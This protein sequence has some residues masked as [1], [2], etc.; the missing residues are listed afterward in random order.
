VPFFDTAGAAQSVMDE[1]LH[2][3]GA[4]AGAFAARRYGLRILRTH[5]EDR[6]ANFT[7]FLLIARSPW[8]TRRGVRVKTSIS[9]AP[10]RN[11]VGILFRVLGVFALRDIDLLKIESRPDPGSP[12]DYL[13]YVDLAGGPHEL[14]VA[15]ALDHL[16]EMVHRYRLL[17]VYPRAR[18]PL[19]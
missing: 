11:Q 8:R 7:R 4:I 14:R 5:L 19:S 13:F 18:T 6:S 1:G 17:G 12:F 3:T 16:Q 2:S 10:L 15:R 9:F